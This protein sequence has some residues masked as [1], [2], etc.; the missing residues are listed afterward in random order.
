MKRGISGLRKRVPVGA[1]ARETIA[2]LHI[3][4]NAGSQFMRVA[5][6]INAESETVRI[7]RQA[8]HRRLGSLEPEQRY[9]FSIRSPISRFRSGFYSR[10]RKGAPKLYAEWT[11]HEARAFER[12]EHANDLAEALFEGGQRG[13]DALSAIKSI[14][15]CAMDQIGWFD[16]HGNFLQIRP[17][18]TIVRQEKFDADIARF[19]RLIGF[20]RPVQL[21]DDT[22][23]A[24]QNDYSG[25]APLSDKARENLSRWYAQDLEFYRVCEFW[26]SQQEP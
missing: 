4:K 10:K 16:L 20:H 18:I 11:A 23:L 3:G 1:E 12:F 14:K 8:H 15:H 22:V 25:I 5:E 26:L 2:F 7:A 24:H 13:L 21:S 9:V 19:L 6:Q 17:P